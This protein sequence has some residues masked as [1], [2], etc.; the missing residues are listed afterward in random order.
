MHV[1]PALSSTAAVQYLVVV[2]QFV[3]LR[4]P[5]GAGG[6]GGLHCVHVH[7]DRHPAVHDA[8][9]RGRASNGRVGEGW[10][11]PSRLTLPWSSMAQRRLYSLHW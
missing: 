3:V 5:E 4:E 2:A 9:C 11:V 8:V 7:H 6:E 10:P 1:S